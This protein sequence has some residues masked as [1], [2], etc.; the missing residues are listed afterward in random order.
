MDAGRV[1]IS[2]DMTIL[3][4]HIDGGERGAIY[5]SVTYR[6]AAHSDVR[7]GSEVEGVTT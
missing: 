2:H 3:C 4:R 6:K 7:T 1:S 5:L